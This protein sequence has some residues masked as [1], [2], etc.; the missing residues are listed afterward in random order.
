[1]NSKDR[2]QTEQR[3]I[4]AVGELI[5]E[6]GFETLGVRRV[7]ER[8]GVNKTLIYRYFG[9]LEGLARAYVK[10]HDFWYNDPAAAGVPTDGDVGAF[11]KAFYRR[12]IARYRSDVVLKRLRRSEISSDEDFM[13]DVRARREQNGVRFLE[14]MSGY[15][16]VDKSVLQAITALMDAG[17]AYLTMFEDGGRMYNG[18]DVRSDAGWEQIAGGIDA[19]IDM[20]VKKEDTETRKGG[21]LWW[22][23]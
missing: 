11:L 19:L 17:I 13:A 20:L 14:A 18:I 8:A 15:A 10:R 23:T 6:E 21:R 9:S 4:D 2:E 7:A 22:K 5:V 3:L 1:M 12:E 16:R